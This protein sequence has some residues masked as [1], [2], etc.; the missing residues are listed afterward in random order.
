[1]CTWRAACLSRTSC[2]IACA[3]SSSKRVRHH[4]FLPFGAAQQDCLGRALCSLCLSETVSTIAGQGEVGWVDGAGPTARFNSPCGLALFK[5]HLLLADRYNHR[6]RQIAIQVL[7]VPKFLCP[8]SAGLLRLVW[9]AQ[10][11]G[12]CTVSSVVGNG[13]TKIVDGPAG[14]ASLSAPMYLVVAGDAVFI[15]SEFLNGVVKWDTQT[16]EHRRRIAR[17]RCCCC[18]LRCC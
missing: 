18:L 4:K 6:V 10:D 17:K 9:L 1:M 15:S 16:G 3:V 5:G 7:T 11:D 2:R 13:G 8:F 12:K 14:E